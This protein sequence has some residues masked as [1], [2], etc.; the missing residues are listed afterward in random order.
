[1]ID[2]RLI[3]DRLYDWSIINQLIINHQS[4]DRPFDKTRSFVAVGSPS[5]FPTVGRIELELTPSYSFDW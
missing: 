3:D 4:V 2:N 5:T 1:M